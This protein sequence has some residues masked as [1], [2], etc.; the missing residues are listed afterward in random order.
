LKGLWGGSFVEICRPGFYIQKSTRGK[1]VRRRKSAGQRSTYTFGLG[2]LLYVAKNLQA[3][4]Y[5]Q[6]DNENIGSG[7][8]WLS[9]KTDGGRW[10]ERYLVRS[11]YVVDMVR[12]RGIRTMAIEC[13]EG[14]GYCRGLHC[15][16]APVLRAC[17]CTSDCRQATLPWCGEHHRS[18]SA[19]TG[20]PMTTVCPPRPPLRTILY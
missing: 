9:R 2:S 5:V 16:Q 7:G 17:G 15:R 20:G 4:G 1:D 12:T 8:T 19:V 6:R 18:H 3:R 13:L 11:L 10:L 14:G